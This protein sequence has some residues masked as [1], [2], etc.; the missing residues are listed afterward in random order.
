MEAFKFHL[1][2]QNGLFNATSLE[3]VPD[4][5]GLHQG[6]LILSLKIVLISFIDLVNLGVLFIDMRCKSFHLTFE[7]PFAK[8]C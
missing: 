6:I 7:C 3:I 4:F 1:S 2:L 5:R 8:T